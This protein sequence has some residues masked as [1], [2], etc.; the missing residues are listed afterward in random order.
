MVDVVAVGRK[1]PTPAV[2]LETTLGDMATPAV[3]AVDLTRASGSV[4][5]LD[6]RFSRER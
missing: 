6:P 1:V 2:A 4:E 3:R 5:A